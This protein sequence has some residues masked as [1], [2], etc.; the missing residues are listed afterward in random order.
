MQPNP[1]KPIIA[2]QYVRETSPTPEPPN[3][4]I[5]ALTLRRLEIATT[6]IKHRGSQEQSVQRVL[7]D[8]ANLRSELIRE[9]KATYRKDP[10]LHKLV[11]TECKHLQR[12]IERA[13]EAG[14]NL[15]RPA[16]QGVSQGSNISPA[17]WCSTQLQQV[18]FFIGKDHGDKKWH[19]QISRHGP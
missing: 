8:A 5:L 10:S 19:G 15:Q 18:K 2:W 11:T 12:A 14:E 17:V 1:T 4:S 6:V 16:P 3:L 13:Q 7:S 9:A